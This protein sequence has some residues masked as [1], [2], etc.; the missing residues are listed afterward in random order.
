MRFEYI[1]YCLFFIWMLSSCSDDMPEP[2]EEGANNLAC[3]I[4][5]EVWEAKVIAGMGVEA[6]EAH[7]FQSN[8][9]LV[10]TARRL[11]SDVDEVIEL[12]LPDVTREDEYIIGKDSD[13]EGMYRF[14]EGSVD[15]VYRTS[16]K[17]GGEV[18]ITRLNMNLRI[19]A[20]TF[21]FDVTDG[22]G[23]EI[24]LREGWFD[25]KMKVH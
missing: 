6:T 15:S 16:Q 7:F 3:R 5:G 11:G 10:I 12:T 4:D 14:R 18:V 24:K 13:A 1:L 9:H 19:V 22:Q 20:G 8:N 17:R 25:L 23:E 2:T 21:S